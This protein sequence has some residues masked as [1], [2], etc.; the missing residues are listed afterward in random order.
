[1]KLL[2]K[3][4]IY[5]FCDLFEIEIEIK[6]MQIGGEAHCIKNKIILDDEFDSEDT[7][8]SAV[9]HEVCHILAYRDRKFYNYHKAL[10]TP[11][12]KKEIKTAYRA[13]KYV[14]TKGCE[15]FSSYFDDLEYHW[16]YTSNRSRLWL[17]NYLR[18]LDTYY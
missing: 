4:Q 14:D 9:C 7:M 13:E 8:W 2:H 1:M 18:T 15:M 17:N 3:K 10:N 16:T 5:S 11:Q 12:V 6:P